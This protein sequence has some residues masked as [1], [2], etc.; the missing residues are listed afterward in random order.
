[1]AS[2]TQPD[3]DFTQDSSS[4]DEPPSTLTD[5]QK[6]H[7]ARNKAAAQ[8]KRAK[9]ISTPTRTL[10]LRTHPDQLRTLWRDVTSEGLTFSVIPF[11]GHTRGAYACFSNFFGSEFEFT[12]PASCSATP[13]TSRVAFGEQAIVACKAAAMG[14]WTSYDTISRSNTNPKACKALDRKVK[15]F[16]Q[17]VW[18]GVVVEVAI[19]IAT[20]KFGSDPALWKVLNATG[21]RVLAEMTRYD[22][23]WG[24]GIDRSHA[25]EQS[26]SAW[27]GTN[28]LGYALMIAR[29]RLRA[30]QAGSTAPA[31]APTP[32]LSAPPPDDDDDDA[33]DDAPST[34]SRKRKAA[35]VSAGGSA[36]GGPPFNIVNG[37]VL[38]APEQ[39]LLHQTNAMKDAT[40]ASA[41]DIDPTRKTRSRVM[42]SQV[43]GKYKHALICTGPRDPRQR[44]GKAELHSGGRRGVANLFAQLAPRKGSNPKNPFGAEDGP[45]QRLARFEQA[46]ADFARQAAALSDGLQSVAMPMN[47]GCGKA[48]GPGAYRA[49]IERFAARHPC[50]VVLYHYEP[51]KKKRRYGR[52]K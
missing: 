37:S 41:A 32:V 5:E 38:D 14:D 13:R 33:D 44:V 51:P 46:L 42:A 40:L 35:D 22:R 16:R 1:M 20:Q 12:L 11:Y 48:G 34:P 45:A 25:D 15:P 10:Q 31:A 52:R 26:T 24:T 4:D 6:T 2:I 19:E 43:F 39:W 50:R 9:V 23:H 36:T 3:F 21:D 18:T 7:I 27:P 8:A 49:A 29:E 30:R 28:I 17:D 47:I